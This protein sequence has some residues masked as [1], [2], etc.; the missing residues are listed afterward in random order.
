MSLP[1]TNIKRIMK[2]A[3]AGS[4]VVQVKDDAVEYMADKMVEFCQNLTKNSIELAKKDG[5]KGIHKKHLIRALDSIDM[6]LKNLPK[7]LPKLSSGGV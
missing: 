3:I 2:A 7:A 6:V 1:K 5:L 4:T